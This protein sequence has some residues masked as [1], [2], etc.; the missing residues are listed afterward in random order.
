MFHQLQSCKL[1]KHKLIIHPC[2]TSPAALKYPLAARP[3]ADL[4]SLQGLSAVSA[5]QGTASQYLTP[6]SDVGVHAKRNYV[7]VIYNEFN[8]RALWAA[9]GWI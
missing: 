3:L 2:F 8:F 9:R 4:I 7:R 1:M 5:W 6:S